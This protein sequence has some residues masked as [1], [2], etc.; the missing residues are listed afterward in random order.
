MTTPDDLM[1]EARSILFTAASPDD[2]EAL[3][4]L[5]VEVMRESLERIGRF[6]PVRA[7]ERFL[8]GFSPE[9]A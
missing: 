7:S 5:R 9:H 6:D 3:A 2:A 8:T 4:T 1:H